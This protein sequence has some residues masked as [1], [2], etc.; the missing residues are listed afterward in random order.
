MAAGQIEKRIGSAHKL[1]HLVHSPGFGHKRQDRLGQNIQRVFDRNERFEEAFHD[2]PRGYGRPKQVA[3]Y[4]GEEDG[5]A[6]LSDPMPGPSDAL[7]GG[8]QARGV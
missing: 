6:G 8:G 4:E 7:R 3:G 1:E 2:A 5:T